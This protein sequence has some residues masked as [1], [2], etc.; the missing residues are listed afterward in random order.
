MRPNPSLTLL[1]TGLVGAALALGATGAGCGDSG[2]Q[3]TG[4]G[5]QGGGAEG[6]GGQG[7]AFVDNGP[8]LFAA[9]E[10]DLIA[11]CASCHE[12][13]GLGD[14]PFLAEPDR[15]QSILS[16]PG[17]VV[18]NVDESLFVTYAVSGGGHSGTQLD[19][20]P[21]DLQSRVR[22]WLEV[23]SAAISDAPVEEAPHVEPIT[24]ILGFNAIYLTG[25]SDELEGVA[26]TFT[27]ELLTETSLK[28]NDLQVHA[29]SATGVH[30]VHPV[31]AVYPKGKPAEADPVDSFAGFDQ[32]FDE[33]TSNPMGVGTLIL[34]N[35][36]ENAKLGVGFESIEPYLSGT[37]EGGG[38]GGGGDPGGG[39]ADL[40]AFETSA[41]PQF[42][43]RCAS[44]HGG[45][46]GQATS[47]V[48]MSELDGDT[49]AACAQIK[50]R[51]NPAD[52]PASQIFVTT[53]PGGNAGHPFKFGGN[54][55]QFNTFRDAVTV[56][57]EAE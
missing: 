37:G 9:L 21:N 10:E 42:T 27:A 44:C 39:C 26:I 19:L 57:I 48:D 34:T 32:R 2:F 17:I 14:A 47:A 18:K 41:L 8:E 46:N 33:G 54:A 30:M 55:G 6:A 11:Q 20:A 28:L 53:D 24:P 51:V 23:E 31:F 15:Y 38:G 29:T 22:E 16:W 25:L 35:W 7:G 3:L 45:S 49:A 56:W 12:P 13:A 50:N 5:G 40:D 36:E 43:Q 4:A 1:L 52:P